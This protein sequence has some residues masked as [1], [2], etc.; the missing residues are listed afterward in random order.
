MIDEPGCWTPKKQHGMQRTISKRLVKNA[1]KAFHPWLDIENVKLG[2][3]WWRTAAPVTAEQDTSA[4]DVALHS[5]TLDP[6]HRLFWAIMT[7]RDS[8]AEVLWKSLPANGSFAGAFMCSFAIRNATSNNP[9][10]SAAHAIVWNE[11]TVRFLDELDKHL[12]PECVRAVFDE[13]LFFGVDEEEYA[14]QYPHV[15]TRYST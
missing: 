10:V 3:P 2:E 12:D 5:T 4:S 13:Y 1:F 9:V 11:K 15:T 8:L 14:L 7:N 6:L